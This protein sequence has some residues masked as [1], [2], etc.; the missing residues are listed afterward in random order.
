MEKIILIFQ[1]INSKNKNQL[2]E[3]KKMPKPQ[4]LTKEILR[5]RNRLNQRKCR[6]NKRKDILDLMKQKKIIKIQLKEYKSK[7]EYIKNHICPQCTK[8]INES[9]KNFEIFQIFQS[10]NSRSKNIS[11][12][13]SFK[14][15][16][17]FTI[18]TI[19]IFLFFNFSSLKNQNNISFV[20][21]LEKIIQI[22]NLKKD[23]IGPT[24]LN[25]KQISETLRLNKSGIFLSFGDF[26]SITKK[27]YFLES[28]YDFINNGKIRVIKDSSYAYSIPK[29]C[30]KCLLEISKDNII[31]NKDNLHFK[32]F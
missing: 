3:I 22:R 11:K 13:F 32:L 30:D 21:N 26:Y 29:K 25:V 24:Y 8:N 23:I 7:Y 5:E 1:N 14:N 19:M 10:Q 4:K 16:S 17:I 20:D 31:Q 28:K 6:I 2:F 12:Y 9:N 15:T 27:N 18:I